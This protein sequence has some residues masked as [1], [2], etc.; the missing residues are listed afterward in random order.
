MD[1]KT[2]IRDVPDFPQEGILFRDITP[3]LLDPVAFNGAVDAIIEQIG[4]LKFDYILGPESRGFIFGI[5]VACKM[6]KGFIPVRKAGKLP[7][8]TLQKVYDLEYGTATIE[9]HKDAIKPGDTF[10]IID[11][12][13][14]TG[15]TASA[16][17][18]LIKEAGG[19]VVGSFFFIELDALEGRDILKDVSVHGV[20]HY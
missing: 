8:E 7:C 16:I 11:D 2:I 5:P 17:V 4:D 18:D 3:L 20:V 14:A 6:N 1:F 19:E 12:L 13:L 10:I 9:I 15:G